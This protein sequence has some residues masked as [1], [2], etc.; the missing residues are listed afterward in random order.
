MKHHRRDN[1]KKNNKKNI[2]PKTKESKKNEKEEAPTKKQ[3][4]ITDNTYETPKFDLGGGGNSKSSDLETNQLIKQPMQNASL[5]M[6]TS[7]LINS[8]RRFSLNLKP[9][10][11]RM[12]EARSLCDLRRAYSNKE[13]SLSGLVFFSSS[14]FSFKNQNFEIC[15]FFV[16]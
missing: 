2:I 11:Y 16:F 10:D 6:S 12:H 4:K 15:F 8:P 7:V 13:H 5:I 3:Q 14:K 9:S 1:S